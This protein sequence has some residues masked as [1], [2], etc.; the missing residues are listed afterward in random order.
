LHF[1]YGEVFAVRFL[2]EESKGG[3]WSQKG[4]LVWWCMKKKE[5][6]CLR[7]WGTV[8]R[9]YRIQRKITESI[10]GGLHANSLNN[11]LLFFGTSRA[12]GIQL[13]TTCW[14]KERQ[15]VHPLCLQMLWI[16]TFFHIS[17]LNHLLNLLIHWT[18]IQAHRCTGFSCSFGLWSYFA[19]YEQNCRCLWL[20][21]SC[22][23]HVPGL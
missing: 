3:S 22:Y 23:Y 10:C 17:M 16:P 21:E 20:S 9:I 7:Y 12:K 13:F 11:R 19:R 1:W 14:N 6:D 2:S 5:K 4:S 15:P 8:E 18:G